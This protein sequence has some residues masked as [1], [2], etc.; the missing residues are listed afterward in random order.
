MKLNWR[1]TE[2]QLRLIELKTSVEDKARKLESESTQASKR[3]VEYLRVLV[4]S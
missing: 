3:D 1:G 4:M 2:Y